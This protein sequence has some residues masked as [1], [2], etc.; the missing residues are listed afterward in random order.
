MTVA[1]K[2]SMVKLNTIYAATEVP[3]LK[4]FSMIMMMLLSIYCRIETVDRSLQV[5]KYRIDTHP[6]G[7]KNRNKIWNK[8]AKK[9]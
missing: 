2:A 7:A 4:R 9:Q 8:I 1:I 5:S 3:G 6:N